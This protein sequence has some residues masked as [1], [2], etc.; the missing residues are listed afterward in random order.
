MVLS[1]VTQASFAATPI[2]AVYQVSEYAV[3]LSNPAYPSGLIFEV[4][5]DGSFFRSAVGPEGKSSL[6]EQGTLSDHTLENFKADLENKWLAPIRTECTR[7]GILVDGAY[8]RVEA[9]RGQKFEEIGCTLYEPGIALKN[10]QAMMAG[11]TELSARPAGPRT[12]S[13]CK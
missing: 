2:I 4:C 13:S 7:R 3:D 10:F 12:R 8:L 9:R 1:V 6:P 5:S 11:L